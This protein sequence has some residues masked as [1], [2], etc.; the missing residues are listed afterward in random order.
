[1][2]KWIYILAAIVCMGLAACSDDSVAPYNGPTVELT[3]NLSL[4]SISRAS[5]DYVVGD[6]L[7]EETREELYMAEGDVY[8]LIFKKESDGANVLCYVP[9]LEVQGTQGDD[10]RVLK[11]QLPKSDGEYSLRVAVNLAQ[12]GCLGNTAAEVKEALRSKIG[13][14]T[15]ETALLQELKFNYP[16]KAWTINTNAGERYL[17]M[18]GVSSE[19]FTLNEDKYLDIYNLYRSVAKMEVKVDEK[20]QGA[21]KLKEIQVL[22]VNETGHIFSSKTPN[23][24][25]EIQY[26]EPDV[27]TSWLQ[28]TTPVSYIAADENGVSSISGIYATESDNINATTNNKQ[29]LRLMVVG[30]LNGQTGTYYIDMIDDKETDGVYLPYDIIR[31]HSYIFNITEVNAKELTVVVEKYTEVPMKGI[32]S[33]YILEVD[34]NVLRFAGV[35]VDPMVI[36]ITTDGVPWELVTQYDNSE[37]NGWFQ[38]DNDVDLQKEH[39]NKGKLTITPTAYIYQSETSKQRT[40]YF[41]VK[42]GKILKRITVIQDPYETANCYIVTKPGTYALHGNVKGNGNNQGQTAGGGTIDIDF[43]DRTAKGDLATNHGEI[44]KYEIIWETI[45]GLVTVDNNRIN[46]ISQCVPYTVHNNKTDQWGNDIFK[47]NPNYNNGYGGNALIGGYDKDGVL[48]WSWHIW[49]IPDY[50]NGVKTETWVTQGAANTVNADGYQMMD[51]YLGAYSNQPGTRSYGLLYQWGR[52]DPFIGPNRDAAVIDAGN[53]RDHEKVPKATTYHYTPYN[54]T[55]GWKTFQT[56]TAETVTGTIENP[57]TLMQY[58]VLS[59]ENNDDGSYP[60]NIAK[61]MWGTSN[62][63]IGTAD[64]GIKTM[65]DPSPVG[66]RVPSIHTFIFEA[67]TPDGKDY[68]SYIETGNYCLNNWFVPD[69]GGF[70]WPL[71]KKADGYG[72]N[73]GVPYHS[74]APFYGFWLKY[75]TNDMTNTFSTTNRPVYGYGKA[76]EGYLT[77]SA[78]AMNFTWLPIGGIY[79]GTMEHFGTCGT[80]ERDDGDPSGDDKYRKPAS[81]IHVNSILWLNAPL[82]NLDNNPAGVFLHGTEG[83]RKNGKDHASKI[84]YIAGRHIHSLSDDREILRALPNYAGNIR[85]VRDKFTH[86]ADI[87]TISASDLTLNSGNSY[88]QTVNVHSNTRWWVSSPGASWVKVSPDKGKTGDTDLTISCEAPTEESPALGPV[89]VVIRFADGTEQRITVTRS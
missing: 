84:N 77:P 26:E 8:V 27:N 51:R 86:V 85:C 45:E 20:I 61:A 82:M 80:V 3:L 89:Y 34:K 57:T 75:D 66:F 7:D 36:N 46:S 73:A 56:S 9:D 44:V 33:Q 24:D 37:N 31:N 47:T 59:E 88:K 11:A 78:A 10:F 58:G 19:T 81:S 38:I 39:P 4:P 79:D 32:N 2:K 68:N 43:D 71:Y 25:W 15:L 55:Y 65:W 41:Y 62:G 49:V 67:K 69:N 28:R 42:A 40:G 35:Y 18:S 6:K 54:N 16:D 21:F 29:P 76:N 1:M 5:G 23:S 13:Q 30:T 64:N 52:K 60:D 12:N 63:T 14:K 87:N 22:N 83:W 48:K 70:N 74:D 17:P 50:D 72:Q 53:G